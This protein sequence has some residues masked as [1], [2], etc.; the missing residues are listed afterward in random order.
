M[1]LVSVNVGA[2]SGEKHYLATYR[3][4]SDGNCERASGMEPVRLLY[5]RSLRM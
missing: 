5:D 2:G 3:T 4:N 1:L